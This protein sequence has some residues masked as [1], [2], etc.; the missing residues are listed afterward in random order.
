M[1]FKIQKIFFFRKK[2]NLKKISVPTLPKIFRHL[3]FNWTS[4]VDVSKESYERYEPRREK[5]NNV[6]VHN[7]KTQ[8]SLGII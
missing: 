4:L 8:S 7:V 2:N 5:T 1:P 6:A 3:F